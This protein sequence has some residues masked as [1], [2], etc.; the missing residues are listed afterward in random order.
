[1]LTNKVS[2]NPFYRKFLECDGENAR[3]KNEIE[4]L[5]LANQKR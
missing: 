2:N 4:E 1:M 5:K 3:L